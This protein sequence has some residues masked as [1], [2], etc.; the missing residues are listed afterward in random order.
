MVPSFYNHLTFYCYTL[1]HL[2]NHQPG[3]IMINDTLMLAA[4]NARNNAQAPYSGYHV[5]AV[6]LSA[7]GN[8]Y[9]GCNVERCSYTQTTHAEQNAIDSMITAEGP[10]QITA[11]VIVAAPKNQVVTL[12][13]FQ[14]AN[15]LLQA[16]QGACCGHC[17]QIIWENAFDNKTLPIYLFFGNNQ[18][19]TTNIGMLLPFPF[20]PSE[21]GIT[22]AH[23]Q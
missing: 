8:I 22:Y 10:A 20:G 16:P 4:I 6:I 5:G 12:Q 19:Y 11:I 3:N 17:L 23:K 7:Q 21:L 14:Q 9:A 2:S 15:I 13:E 1:Y 18:I